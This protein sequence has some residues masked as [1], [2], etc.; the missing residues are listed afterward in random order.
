M[1]QA[2]CPVISNL[3]NSCYL[4]LIFRREPEVLLIIMSLRAVLETVIHLESFRNIDLFFQGIYYTRFRIHT[5][6]KS[7]DFAGGRNGKNGGT[8]GAGEAAA[9]TT[10]TAG[11]GRAA[12]GTA[13]G[14]AAAQS[15]SA[16]QIE[17]AQPYC[18]YVSHY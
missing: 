9:S 17:Y 6:K 4:F 1:L 5:K 7:V 15:T 13:S 3:Y 2:A 18:S 11:D 16:D 12:N 8:N 14:N 10:N